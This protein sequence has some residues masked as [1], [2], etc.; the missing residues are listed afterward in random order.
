[1]ANLKDLRVRIASVKATP[2]QPGV[3]EIRIPSERAYAERARRL[4][5]GIEVPRAIAE[6]IEKI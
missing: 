6:R 5:E 4:V 1:M 3:A 2:R